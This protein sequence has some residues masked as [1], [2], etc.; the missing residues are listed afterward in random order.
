MHNLIGSLTSQPLARFICRFRG[1]FRNKI[2]IHISRLELSEVNSSANQDNTL[3]STS[4]QLKVTLPCL[5]WYS[6]PNLK[7]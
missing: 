7:S 6:Q 1:D 2:F 3:G 5:N 4:N